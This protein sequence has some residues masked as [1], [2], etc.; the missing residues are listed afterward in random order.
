MTS[1]CIRV[2]Q[3]AFIRIDVEMEFGENINLGADDN[4]GRSRNVREFV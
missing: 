1:V 3:N 4:S 2:Y